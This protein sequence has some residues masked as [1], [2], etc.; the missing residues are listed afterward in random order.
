V[1]QIYLPT[2]SVFGLN[3]AQCQ[4]I[5]KVIK[6][7]HP[8]YPP[9]RIPPPIISAELKQHLIADSTF[10]TEMIFSVVN[11]IFS[12]N[13]Q[14]LAHAI[15]IDKTL[16][17]LIEKLSTPEWINRAKQFYRP[18][19][20]LTES[21]LRMVENNIDTPLGGI[22]VCD[23]LIDKFQT[24]AGLS[25]EKL[26]KNGLHTISVV[27]KW[28]EA[29]K[30]LLSN[31]KVINQRLPVFYSAFPSGDTHPEEDFSEQDYNEYIVRSG[32]QLVYGP[33][34]DLTIKNNKVMYKDIEIDVI[35][36]DYSFTEF[37]ESK[38]PYS[39]ID[40]L[41]DADNNNEVL[42]LSPPINMLFDNK[43]ILSFLT[44]DKYSLHFTQDEW[45]RLQKLIPAT[46]IITAE[47][48]DFC[49]KNKEHILIK[50]AFGFGGYDVYP[51]HE[52]DANTW[53]AMVTA[54]ANSNFPTVVQDIVA[55]PLKLY[56]SVQNK[57]V[58]FCLGPYFFGG[59]FSGCFYREAAG[60][61][62]ATPI[63]N[64]T[65]GAIFSAVYFSNE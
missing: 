26:Q 24:G 65:R 16:E 39:I 23:A 7:V 56:D 36:T 32:F 5:E 13:Y 53:K 6:S 9:I 20:L 35:Y 49:S 51:G 48:Q 38:Q 42:F 46:N 33:I 21:G 54:A 4:E 58:S 3:D 60:T 19:F 52:Y 61:P 44:N 59:I 30:K 22:G 27:T 11:R 8:K 34:A 62:S 1:K 37:I 50:P 31:K 45:N 17:T 28:S 55:D 2:P 12:G 14:E 10:I 29:I 18:D 43:A 63:I 64:A 15:K 40:A 57:Y 41:I 25:A 47:L